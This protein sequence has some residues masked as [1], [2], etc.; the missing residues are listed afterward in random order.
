M[1]NVYSAFLVFDQMIYGRRRVWKRRRSRSNKL[2]C[3]F[4]AEESSGL[5]IRKKRVI[6]LTRNGGIPI[7]LSRARYIVNI[8]KNGVS[9]CAGTILAADIIITIPKCIA[10]IHG[11]TYTILSN[12][13]LRDNGTAHHVERR[14]SEP[15]MDFGDSFN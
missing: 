7:R 2:I 1:I 4:S 10:E 9:H 3:I 5:H 12:S 14:S 15:G 11:V 6:D 8:Q 13:A